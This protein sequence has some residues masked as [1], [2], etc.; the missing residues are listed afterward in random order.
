[1]RLLRRSLLL[2]FSALS[3]GFGGLARTCLPG[4]ALKLSR[5]ARLLV[6]LYAL[7]LGLGGLTPARLQLLTLSTTRLHLSPLPLEFS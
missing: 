7:S 2:L 5:L 4:L 6:L 1:V 3:L